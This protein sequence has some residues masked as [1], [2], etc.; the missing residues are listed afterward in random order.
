MMKWFVSILLV[1]TMALGSNLM[2][3]GEAYAEALV[4]A[5]PVVIEKTDTYRAY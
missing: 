1:T 4:A 3:A 2:I 5:Q